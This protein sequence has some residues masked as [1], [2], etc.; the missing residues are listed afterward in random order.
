MFHYENLLCLED[1]G[2]TELAYM[3]LRDQDSSD[4]SGPC[5]DDYESS[6]QLMLICPEESNHENGSPL[7]FR[8]A[9]E[10]YAFQELLRR[11]W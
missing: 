10:E 9:D 4:M 5:E 6:T 2:D 7:N 11:G 1:S 3:K 8:N